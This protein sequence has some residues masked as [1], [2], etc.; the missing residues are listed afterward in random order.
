MRLT[1]KSFAAGCWLFGALCVAPPAHA[2]IPPGPLLLGEGPVCPLGPSEPCLE[3]TGGE[4]GLRLSGAFLSELQA[5]GLSAHALT[6]ATGEPSGLV[7]MPLVSVHHMVSDVPGMLQVFK[8][9]FE[10]DLVIRPQDNDPAAAVHLSR[11]RVDPVTKTILATVTGGGLGRISF[12]EIFHFST[13]EGTD[14]LSLQP[15]DQ[16]MNQTFSGLT[17]TPQALGYY[18]HAFQLNAEDL[19]RLAQISD[20]GSLTLTASIT[21]VVPEPSAWM[22]M[23]VGLCGLFALRN[24]RFNPGR[25]RT[26]SHQA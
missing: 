19:A 18:Q 15:G 23:G 21:G 14:L 25:A 24:L 9:G 16:T 8:Y 20:A 6:P 10:G 5:S 1:L 12:A 13:V 4:A 3:L 17:L 22:L 7:S 11:W 2:G 26:P